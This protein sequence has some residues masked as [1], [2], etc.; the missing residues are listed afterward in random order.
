VI[1]AAVLA[2][3]LSTRM[4]GQ[5]KALLHC[6]DRDTF[7]TRIIRTFV[8]SGIT[9]IVV[10]VGHAADR[11]RAVVD[12]SGLP[13]RCV[14]NPAYE[15]GQLSSLVTAIDSVD[16]PDV[17]GVLL[18][19]VDAPFF[20]ERTVRAVVQQ[21]EATHVP[22]VRPTRGDEHG[23]PVLIAKVL[24]DS[25]RRADPAVG[26][27]PII[28]A[29]TSAAGDIPIDDAGA[30]LDVDTPD[31]YERITGLPRASRSAES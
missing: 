25:I 31:D 16:R 13:A 23:H 8:A 30:F 10:I 5:P 26:A 22:V 14:V 7:V 18:A 12:A 9:E 17:D 20:R 1:A 21:F 19:L 4:G 2:A 28:R 11:V 15:R 29:N 3:G 6:D 24:F 27:K